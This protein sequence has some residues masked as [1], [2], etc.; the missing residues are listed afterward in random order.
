MTLIAFNKTLYKLCF[1][2][3]QWVFNRQWRMWTH[4]REYCWQLQ[5]WVWRRIHTSQE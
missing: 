5:V 2:R 3:A 1:C 4:L